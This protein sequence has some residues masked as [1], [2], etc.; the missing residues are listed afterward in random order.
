[1]KKE[2]LI[3]E[4]ARLLDEANTWRSGDENRRRLLTNIINGGSRTPEFYS[5]RQNA[6]L[7]WLEIAAEIG[8]FIGRDQLVEAM[9]R[10]E[11][12]LE[13]LNKPPL[14]P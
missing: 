13:A 9:D 5:N 11:K 2:E 4:N 8:K 10:N 12:L 1:M 6:P 3:K 7:S 14:A